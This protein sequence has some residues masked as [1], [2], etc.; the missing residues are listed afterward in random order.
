MNKNIVVAIVIILLFLCSC[1]TETGSDISNSPEPSE[2]PEIPVIFS[3]D[4]TGMTL[5]ETIA[6][7]NEVGMDYEVVEE[8]SEEFK[9]GLIAAQS[10]EPE[11]VIT[12]DTSIILTIS[13][14][15]EYVT[16][17]DFSG[18]TKEESIELIQE[19]LLSYEV[20]EINHNS[21]NEGYVISHNPGP[22][23]KAKIGSVV[24]INVSIGPNMILM[25]DLVN[26]TEAYVKVFFSEIA[27]EYEITYEQSNTVE[28][29]KVISQSISAGDYAREGDT[30]SIII[31][32]GLVEFEA[33]DYSGKSLQE[34][35]EL[36]SGKCRI[37]TR[38]EYNPHYD[39]RMVI[40]QSVDPGTLMNIESTILLTINDLDRKPVSFA[41]S[42]LEQLIRAEINKKT[43]SILYSDVK[44]IIN[45]GNYDTQHDKIKNL[46]GIENLVSLQSLNLFGEEI[47][48]VT[49]LSGLTDLRYLNLECNDIHD[50]SLLANLTELEYIALSSNPI[51][52]ISILAN[53]KDLES[54]SLSGCPVS[55]ISVIAD[56]TDMEFLNV[57]RT[58]I[59]PQE[60]KDIVSGFNNLR[61]LHITDIK[62]RD[63]NFLNCH[64]TLR[65]LSADL[66]DLDSMDGL[67][68]FTYLKSL[69][70]YHNNIVDITPLQNLSYL[71]SLWIGY[72]NIQDISPLSNLTNLYYLFISSIHETD[73]SVLAELTKLE[74]LYISS[75]NIKNVEFLRPLVNLRTLEIV[76]DI[77]YK[78]NYDEIM[79]EHEARGCLI[80]GK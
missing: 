63:L 41:S 22:D 64:D 7:L 35:N 4:L 5:D 51:T 60:L 52:D 57:S 8:H 31:S 1:S 73:F 11:S 6:L 53:M 72:N 33:T 74:S 14:G 68:K 17:P 69:R 67:E 27:L 26:H 13:K 20:V 56:Y 23:S 78:T 16:L 3:H 15:S 19:K 55:S 24:T 61:A 46:Q 2:I 43:G 75:N 44:D 42:G 62:V 36:L 28:S 18:M 71:E 80:S 50:I 45:L 58:Y 37:E 70:I 59:D 34:A 10:I 54:V 79:D 66:C 65:F 9:K 48:D 40:S 49:P 47:T 38:Y 39:D 32:E 21:I 29:G 76:S 77:Q 30:I 12:E 25:E